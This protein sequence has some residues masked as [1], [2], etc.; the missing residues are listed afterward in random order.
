MSDQD[1]I[2]VWG[3]EIEGTVRWRR[4]DGRNR[5]QLRRLAGMPV[6]LRFV[7]TDADLFSLRFR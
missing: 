7:M 4:A 3:D 1:S 5:D 6:R 2:P